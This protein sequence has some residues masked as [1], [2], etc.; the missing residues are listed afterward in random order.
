MSYRENITMKR[1]PKPLIV[2]IFGIVS[3]VVLVLGVTTVPAFKF[4]ARVRGRLQQAGI[5]PPSLPLY[6]EPIAP[7]NRVT[8]RRLLVAALHDA[9]ARNDYE[10]AAMLNA[11]LSQ[12]AFQRAYRTL[13][14]WETVRDPNTGL[15]P[16]ATS[17]WYRQWNLHA[18][19][20]NLFSHLL[21][22][23]YY[24]DPVNQASWEQVIANER[25]ICGAMPCSIDIPSGMVVEEDLSDDVIGAAIEY[26]RDGLL[27]VTERLGP[28]LWFDR[29]REGTDA[30]LDAAHV[31]TRA[32]LI[33]S[34]ELQDNGAL[35]QLLPR[36]YWATGDERYLQMAER[37]AEAYLFEVFLNDQ[38]LP[39]DFW[40]F[41]AQH[42]IPYV[43]PDDARFLSSRESVPD[44]YLFRLADHGGEIIP[45]L[46]EL[47]F[48]ERMLNR[49]Q[50]DQYRQPLQEF[51]EKVLVTGRTDE[52]PW[53]RSVDVVT[54]EPFNYELND[55]W[56]YILVG[57]QTFDLAEGTDRYA[58][59]IERTMRTVATKHSINWEGNQQD[60]YADT[61]ESM[62]YLLP[63]FDIPEAHYWVD[64]E[65]EIM[66]LKQ[67]SDGFVEGWFLDGNFVRTALLYAQYKTQGLGLE[68]WSERVRMGATLDRDSDT[69]YVYLAAQGDWQGKL[70][71]DTPRHRIIWNLPI[72]YPRVNEAPEW[73]VVEPESV[74]LV[75]NLDT[76]E[77]S[78]YSGQELAEGL[79]ITLHSSEDNVLRLTVSQ[80]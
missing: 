72:E 48:L 70:R 6:E 44:L 55:T 3:L 17:S 28:G 51:L 8:S 49:P 32:G 77:V 9:L 41:E 13:K 16:W 23:S 4:K 27:G 53:Y 34:N 57:F 12:E 46:A 5:L 24:L 76:G 14:A 29:L 11:I 30:I 25:E 59:E 66:F 67:R 37:I 60:G 15:V 42:P 62:L 74:Y 50:A 58:S 21:I 2:L 80:Q 78:S 38:G 64:D 19:G 61:I 26:T 69:L 75:A 10:Q 18:V 45:G 68:P 54:L 43:H 63:W 39:T 65:I 31:E 40:D 71:F 47:Y 1:C 52:G 36:L 56:G 22:A 79:P 33:P 7:P 73:Y 20:A 35:L